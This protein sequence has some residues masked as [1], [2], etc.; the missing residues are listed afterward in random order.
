[1]PKYAV[2]WCL[3]SSI[4]GFLFLGKCQM[5]KKRKKGKK[6][7]FCILDDRYLDEKLDVVGVQHYFASRWRFVSTMIVLGREICAKFLWTIWFYSK[8][9]RYDQNAVFLIVTQSA[10]MNSLIIFLSFHFLIQFF[11]IKYNLYISYFNEN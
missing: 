11:K 10:T 1:L 7:S 9:Y 3:L 2:F 4:V 6:R 5:S 8:R